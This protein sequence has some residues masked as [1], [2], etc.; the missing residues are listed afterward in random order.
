MIQ[1]ITYENIMTWLMCL[2][3][4]SF[5][6]GK[7]FNVVGGL[8]VVLFLIHIIKTRSFCLFKDKIFIFLSIWCGYMCLTALWAVNKA[9]AVNSASKVFLW[10]L[11]YLAIKESLSTKEKLENFFKFVAIIVLLIAFNALLQIAIGYNMFGT[12]IKDGRVSDLFYSDSR[13]YSYILP[14]FVGIFGAMLSLKDRLKSHYVL[15]SL[16]LFALLI[17]MPASGSRGPLIILAVFIPVIAWVSPYRKYAFAALGILIL[18]ISAMV[19]TNDKLQDRLTTL[20]NPFESQKHYRI[21]IWKTSFEMFKDNPI[22]GVGF[23]NFRDRQFDY[24]KDEFESYEIN[25]EKNLT[26]HHSHSPWMDI[27]AEQGLIGFCFGITLLVGVFLRI[28]KKGAFMFISTFSVLYAFSFLNSSYI[29]SGSR[30]A[31]FMIFAITLFVLL[32][33][34]Y[35]LIT[36]K[37]NE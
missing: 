17:S 14:L 19:L 20:S 27:L 10:V 34:Y 30:T 32:D 25:K 23:K 16:A 1:K 2:L 11:L 22:L 36:K 26:V 7:S 15:Y 18:C 12:A 8:I 3:V 4:V 35:G 5:F 31:F 37:D 29:L 21:A 33:N 6:I 28:Y 13:D 24:Y 9:G